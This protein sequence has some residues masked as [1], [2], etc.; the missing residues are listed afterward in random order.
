[1]GR[2]SWTYATSELVVPRS[3]P[4]GRGAALGSKISKRTI[5]LITR[6][7]DRPRIEPVFD[8]AHLV[9]KPPVIAKLTKE[10]RHVVDGPRT[11]RGGE[12]PGNARDGICFALANGRCQ[13][14]DR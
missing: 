9:E 3:I 14:L 2:P 6:D 11:L 10:R 13:S 1:M 12:R 8:R 5:F 4:I 7:G